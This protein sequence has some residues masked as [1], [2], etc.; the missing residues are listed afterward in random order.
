MLQYTSRGHEF[1]SIWDNDD[2]NNT[3]IQNN[4][5]NQL[6]LI[7]PEMSN[8]HIFIY[9]KN[10][11]GENQIDKT[12]QQFSLDFDREK[13]YIDRRLCEDRYNFFK[14]IIPLVNSD[15]QLNLVLL[16]CQQTIFAY[17][18]KDLYQ[19]LQ[20]HQINSVIIDGREPI[21]IYLNKLDSLDVQIRVEKEMLLIDQFDHD[22]IRNS[23]KICIFSES[24]VDPMV[25]VYV[26]FYFKLV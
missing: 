11:L 14:F 25:Y 4:T 18:L 2:S 17:V 10:K 26:N 1:I 6:S 8:E 20:Q 19:V 7:V 23:I 13:I 16:M 21:Q 12:I 9:S 5:S 15:Q 24:M 22:L 3:N